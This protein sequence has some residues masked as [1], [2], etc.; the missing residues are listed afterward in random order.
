ME[1][2]AALVKEQTEPKN[3]LGNKLVED[4][5]YYAHQHIGSSS[6]ILRTAALK[7]LYEVSSAQ[8]IDH[9]RN[10]FY[11]KAVS[12]QSSQADP[13][14][15]MLL[16]LIYLNLLYD[17]IESREYQNLVKG[18]NANN[19]VKVYNPDNEKNL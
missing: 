12:F 10:F 11:A 5:I 15:I 16:I 7:I 6:Q 9:I 18:N 2:L 4:Y 3:N 14:Q 8:S 17:L 13:E 19:L 1:W